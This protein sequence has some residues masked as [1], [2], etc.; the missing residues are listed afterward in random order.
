MLVY[1]L[2]DSLRSLVRL[3]ISLS[4]VQSYNQHEARMEADMLTEAGANLHPE[5]GPMRNPWGSML[6]RPEPNNVRDFYSHNAWLA[7]G[8]C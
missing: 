8:F 6:L 2:Y 1:C 7:G 4:P 3:L 5:L